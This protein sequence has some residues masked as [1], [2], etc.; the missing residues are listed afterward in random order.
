VQEQKL[1]V[2]EAGEGKAVEHVHG[3]V[4]GFL[5]VLAEACVEEGVHSVLKLK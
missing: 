3:E 1:A 2:D 5:A 4:I